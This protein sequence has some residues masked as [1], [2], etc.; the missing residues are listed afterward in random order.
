MAHAEHQGAGALHQDADVAQRSHQHGQVDRHQ[1]AAGGV[2]EAQADLRGVL[3][4]PVIS[5]PSSFMLV[6][7]HKLINFFVLEFLV[8]FK[9]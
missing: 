1:A 3:L 9:L 4:G 8:K 6:Y 5:L 2:A 7:K